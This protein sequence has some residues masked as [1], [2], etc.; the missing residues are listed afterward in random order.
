M[1]ASLLV[2]PFIGLRVLEEGGW[3]VEDAD[4]EILAGEVSGW[5]PFGGVTLLIPVVKGGRHFPRPH[6]C[7]AVALR[8]WSNSL[9]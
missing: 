6:S 4:N 5:H 1:S 2:R 8:E 9:G 7:A 3:K